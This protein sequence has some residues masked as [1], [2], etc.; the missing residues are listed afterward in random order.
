M[1]VEVWSD[2]VC[3]W[4]YVGKRNLEAALGAFD[5]ASEVVVRWRSFEL[6]P[7][8][9]PVRDLP[10]ARILER[11]YGMTADQAAEANARMTA[12]AA[13]VGL[14]YDLER[15][16]SANTF[17]AHRLLQLAAGS[18]RDGDLGERLFAAVFT[19]GRIVSDHGVLAEL[20][21]AAGLDPG[22]VTDTLAGD[23]FG[24]AVRDDERRA[25][26]LGVS[27]V[28]FLLVGGMVAVPGAQ[29]PDVVLRALDRAWA[30]SVP[31]QSPGIP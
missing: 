21:A 31:A 13:T 24:T 9:P 5:H 15:M 17:D 25:T 7:G 29:P 6:D 27:G 3:P 20:G 10:L 19:E 8:A 2:V 12:L 23:A 14:T 4:C 11:K 18:G 28:P 30:R 1:D 16:R 22:R 26:E